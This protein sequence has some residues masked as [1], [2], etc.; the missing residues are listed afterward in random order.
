MLQPVSNQLTDAF[1]HHLIRTLTLAPVLLYQGKHVRRNTPTLPEPEGNRTIFSNKSACNILI[2][3]DSSAAGVGASHQNTALLGNL[4]NA[5]SPEPVNITLIAQTGATSHDGIEWMK[6]LPP[7]E[8]ADIVVTVFGVNDVTKNRSLAIWQSEQQA[9]YQQIQNRFKGAK[10]VTCGLPPMARFPAL[11]QPL[12]WYLGKR[13]DEFDDALQQLIAHNPL[14]R[15][16]SLR[17]IDDVST[18]AQDGFH[19]GEPLYQAWGERLAAVI[20]QFNKSKP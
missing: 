5:L 16:F 19:P 2:V 18:M 17:F 10:V 12:R 13:A 15:F 20:A 3:G 7:S 4:R 9:L 11:P 8:R 14:Q 1:V 6:S